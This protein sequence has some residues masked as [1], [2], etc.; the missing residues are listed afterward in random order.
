MPFVTDI[1]RACGRPKRSRLV[2]AAG[3]HAVIG[4]ELQD[5]ARLPGRQGRRAEAAHVRLFARP[6]DKEQVGAGAGWCMK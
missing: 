4:R 3:E 5:S 2:R 1:R 6:H